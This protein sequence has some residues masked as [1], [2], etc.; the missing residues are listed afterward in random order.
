MQ[1]KYQIQ[2]S[3]IDHLDDP[4]FIQPILEFT[5]PIWHDFQPI[6]SVEHDSNSIVCQ[7]TGCDKCRLCS[8]RTKS[9]RDRDGLLSPFTRERSE[10]HVSI[11]ALSRYRLCWYM[12]RY[13]HL[14]FSAHPKYVTFERLSLIWSILRARHPL[15]ASRTKMYTYND[16]RFV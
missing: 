4:S 11:L 10:R 8:V 12:Y 7:R 15:L 6:S 1:I 13:L 5:L 9:W 2:S 14:G 16:V 3:Q